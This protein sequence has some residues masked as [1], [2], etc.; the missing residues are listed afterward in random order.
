MTAYLNNLFYMPKT[1]LEGLKRRMCCVSVNTTVDHWPSFNE[2]WAASICPARLTDDFH[3]QDRSS[4]LTT[5]GRPCAQG[6]RDWSF[7]G[8]Q[9]SGY[10]RVHLLGHFIRLIFIQSDLLETTGEL[11]SLS[12][13]IS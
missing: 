13:T 1:C 5:I 8:K 10:G 9:G 7:D 3:S 4:L 12:L 6:I 2:G 11:F